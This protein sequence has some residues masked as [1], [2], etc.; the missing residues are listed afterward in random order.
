[1][2]FKKGINHHDNKL[3]VESVKQIRSTLLTKSNNY[4]AQKLGVHYSTISL[5]R[6]G[7]TWKHV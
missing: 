7:K 6:T 3:T 5:V 2:G 1:M 4:W